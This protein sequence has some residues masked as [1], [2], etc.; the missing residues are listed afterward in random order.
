M[1]NILQDKICVVF[2]TEHAVS[3]LGEFQR[4][5]FKVGFEWASGDT[6]PLYLGSACVLELNCNGDLVITRNNS[7]P[8][9]DETELSI[10]FVMQKFKE[11][12]DCGEPEESDDE[13][14]DFWEDLG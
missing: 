2:D 10:K 3:L 1:I 13:G 7:L 11:L 12:Q 5:A 14:F 9:T 8:E 4:E 6:T